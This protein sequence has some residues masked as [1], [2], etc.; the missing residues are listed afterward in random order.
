MMQERLNR[1]VSY[2]GAVYE[3][4]NELKVMIPKV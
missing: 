1:T 3:G 4:V 2:L